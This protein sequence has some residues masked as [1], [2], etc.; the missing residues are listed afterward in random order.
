[1]PVL[2]KL[3][4]GALRNAIVTTAELADGTVT[5][6]DLAED[7]VDTSEIKENAVGASE[8]NNA[9]NFTMASATTTAALSVGTTSALQGQ[10]T[11]NSGS[12]TFTLPTGRP[13]SNQILKASNSTGTLA[14]DAISVTGYSGVAW[15]Y[16]IRGGAAETIPLYKSIVVPG[17]MTVTDG[18]VTVNGR[19]VII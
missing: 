17:P 7:S 11:L 13:A 19:L 2:T 18:T 12:N 6:V 4:R 5:A 10:V 3:N 9:G 14:W 15:S 1:M 8:L 16:D